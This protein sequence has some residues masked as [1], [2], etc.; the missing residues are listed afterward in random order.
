MISNNAVASMALVITAVMGNGI[1]AAE[2]TAAELYGQGVHAYFAADYDSAITLLSES[3][4]QNGADPR[5]LLPRAE[6]WHPSRASM[7]GWQI[8]PKAPTSK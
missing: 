3:I 8:L 6:P 4:R 2:P 5:L 1:L 7:P